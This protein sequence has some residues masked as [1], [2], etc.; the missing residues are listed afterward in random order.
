MTD[1]QPDEFWQGVAQFNQHQFYACHDTFESLWMEATE[2]DKKFYQ[3]ILQIAVAFYHLENQ[4]WRGAVILMGE[5]MNRLSDYQPDYGGI[6][7]NQLLADTARILNILQE[8]G[9]ERVS[10]IVQQAGDRTDQTDDG[11]KTIAG[12]IALP[13]LER[14]SPDPVSP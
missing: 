8:T 6:D 5:G 12:A 4:N 14:I 13:R 2:P 7:V 1:S 3:G 9:P 10:E 11:R